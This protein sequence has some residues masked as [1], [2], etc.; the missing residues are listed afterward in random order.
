L[1]KAVPSGGCPQAQVA[2][3]GSKGVEWTEDGITKDN[4]AAEPVEKRG[5]VAQ[6]EDQVSLFHLHIA[7]G[8]LPIRAG[9]GEGEDVIIEI[10][11]FRRNG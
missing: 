9:V 7:Y 2:Q 11:I 4:R 5:G 8:P 1:P 3:G 6:F 10:E